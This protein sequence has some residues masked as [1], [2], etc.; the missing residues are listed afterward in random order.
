MGPTARRRFA[1]ASWIEMAEASSAPSW[2]PVRSWRCSSVLRRG[3]WPGSGAG[4]LRSW[5]CSGL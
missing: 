5:R 4:N 3:R 2:R 1:G